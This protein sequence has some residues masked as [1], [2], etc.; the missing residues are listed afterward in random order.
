MCAQDRQAR[1]LMRTN[2]QHLH[3]NSVTDVC[4][5]HTLLL[6]VCFCLCLSTELLQKKCP[7]RW[8][9]LWCRYD[10]AHVLSS[11]MYVRHK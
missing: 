3:L 1:T 9:R 8:R 10:I 7:W 2:A 4:M 11:F 5:C 6:V